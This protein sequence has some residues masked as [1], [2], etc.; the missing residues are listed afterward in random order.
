MLYTCCLLKRF[1][2]GGN[3]KSRFYLGSGRYSLKIAILVAEPQMNGVAEVW[4]CDFARSCR[5]SLALGKCPISL[6][7]VLFGCPGYDEPGSSLDNLPRDGASPKF[8]KRYHL[9]CQLKE[10]LSQLYHFKPVS[11]I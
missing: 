1:I 9:T 6:V 10:Q 5:S 2:G 7:V 4:T 3:L 8:G 11:E